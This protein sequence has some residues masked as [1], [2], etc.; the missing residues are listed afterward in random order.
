MPIEL[1]HDQWRACLH[2]YVA[3]SLSVD[4][5]VAVEHHLHVCAACRAELREWQVLVDAV[6]VEAGARFTTLPPLSSVVRA[7]LSRRPSAAQAM[8]SAA[9]LIRAQW[10]LLRGLLPAAILVL[11]LGIVGTISLRD[12]TRAALPLLALAPIAAALS[13]AF[14]HNTEADPAWEIVASASTRPGALV[15]ARLTLL[16]GCIVVVLLGGSVAVSLTRGVSFGPLVAA[17]LG[18]LLLL[19]ALATALAVRW[20]ATIAAGASLTLW[21]SLVTVLVREVGG[22]P[23][24]AVS[25]RP[26]LAPTWWLFAS[27]LAGA[28][29]LWW[30]SWRLANHRLMAAERGLDA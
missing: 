24:I 11:I 13:V 7:N 21:I 19:S 26:L 14:L 9:H 23:A 22:S 27:Q 28:A 29:V 17:W 4:E 18:P 5:R 12:D 6:R 3:G 10:P 2:L 25:L 20:S 16:L 8:G 30:I 15:F 1:P